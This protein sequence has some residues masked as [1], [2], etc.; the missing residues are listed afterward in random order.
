MNLKLIREKVIKGEFDL[1]EHAHKE[2]QLEE[3]SVE[4]IKEVQVV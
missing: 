1:S 4:E 2:R 3:I